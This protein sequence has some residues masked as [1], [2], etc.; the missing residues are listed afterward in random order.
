MKKT[1]LLLV[2]IVALGFQGNAQEISQHAIGLR[3]GDNNGMGPEINYQ[4][5]LQENNRLE[6][7]LAWH[8]RS[9]FNSMKATGIY[10]WIWHLQDGFNWYAGPGAGIGVANYKSGYYDDAHRSD[11]KTYA[12]I[13]GDVGIE[14]HFNIPLMLSF[15][16]R[17]QINFGYHDNL[18]FDFGLSARYKF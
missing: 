10:Q 9:Y 7:G 5:A 8:S 14:Y 12:L 16:V 6:F 13:T 3:F 18:S 17:P 11:S 15:D 2:A 4:Y 1:L